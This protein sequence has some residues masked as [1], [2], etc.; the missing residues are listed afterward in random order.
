MAAFHYHLFLI[1]RQGLEYSRPCLGS[2]N[3]FGSSWCGILHPNLRRMGG[4][5]GK[6][7]IPAPLDVVAVFAS[8]LQPVTR[9]GDRLLLVDLNTAPGIIDHEDVIVVVDRH[10]HRGPEVSFPF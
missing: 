7:L 9:E 10:A 4:T 2:L 6:E 5:V 8:C 3:T 1:A